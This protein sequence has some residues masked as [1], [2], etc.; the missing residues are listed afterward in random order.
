M[1][2]EATLAKCFF[3]WLHMSPEM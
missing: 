1:Y 2:L 3:F